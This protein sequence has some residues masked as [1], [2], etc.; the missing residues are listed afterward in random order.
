MAY[1]I[2]AVLCGFVLTFAW[3]AVLIALDAYS[4]FRQAQVVHCPTADAAAAIMLDNPTG[5]KRVSRCSRWPLY[6]GCQ[7]TCL[8]AHDGSNV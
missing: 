5:S 1:P 2:V 8:S 6:Q 4:S 3:L 7:E